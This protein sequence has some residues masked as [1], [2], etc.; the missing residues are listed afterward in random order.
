MYIKCWQCNEELDVSSIE[1]QV[2]QSL[3]I[4]LRDKMCSG[5][6]ENNDNCGSYR[7]ED[8]FVIADLIKELK[9]KL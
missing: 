2:Y 4:K 1:K 6:V 3:I 9:E 7:H 5:S 8:C